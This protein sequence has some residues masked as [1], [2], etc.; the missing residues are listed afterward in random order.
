METFW[1]DWNQIW[2]SRNKRNHKDGILYKF[3]KQK[4]WNK[5]LQLKVMEKLESFDTWHKRRDWKE[6]PY[7][8]RWN[9]LLVEGCQALRRQLW[10]RKLLLS[11]WWWLRVQ[12]L[13]KGGSLCSFGL[14][15]Q[16]FMIIRAK[17]YSLILFGMVG[18]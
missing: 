8:W 17:E 3:K 6:N 5:D 7:Q 14:W 16:L 13:Q 1:T 2:S 10:G 9:K 15:V 18:V 12:E 4:A 11:G